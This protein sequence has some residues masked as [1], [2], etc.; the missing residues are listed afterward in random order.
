MPPRPLLTTAPAFLVGFAFGLGKIIRDCS[1]TCNVGFELAPLAMLSVALLT[2]PLSSALLRGSASLGFGRFAARVAGAVALGFLAFRLATWGL[3]ERVDA[4]R[5]VYLGFFVWLG[6]V[7]ALLG[8]TV[9]RG[10]AELHRPATRAAAFAWSTAAFV[11]GAVVGS[12]VAKLLVPWLEATFGLGYMAARDDLMLLIALCMLAFA[13]VLQRV[14]RLSEPGSPTRDDAMAEALPAD[15][16]MESLHVA[17]RVIRETPVLRRLAGVIFATGVAESLAGFLFYWVV[18]LEVEHADGRTSFFAD[19]QL[20]LN[21]GT[22]LLLLTGSNRILDRFGLAIGIATMP[23]ALAFGTTF[24]VAQLTLTSIYVVRMLEGILEQSV[25]GQG[26]D[27]AVF[28]VPTPHA[29]SVRPV[30]LGLMER[31]GRGVG[32]I[33]VFTGYVGFSMAL[34]PTAVLYLAVLVAWFLGAISLRHQLPRPHETQ[35]RVRPTQGS[36]EP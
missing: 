30:L 28:S 36:T 17:A 25:Y 5:A 8:P 11:G 16:E 9:K 6:A 13:L 31:L 7:G 10:V 4:L 24:V 34:R 12:L 23:L 27:R 15:D 32:A 19:F 21:G 29:E 33:V 20:W 1:L 18:T 35:S 22:F 14:A 3:A 26:L 2:V